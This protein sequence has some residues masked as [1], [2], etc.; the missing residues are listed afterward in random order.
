MIVEAP[1]FTTLK[2]VGG[3]GT[4][5]SRDKINEMECM[6]TR[7]ISDLVN[8]Q[9][10]Y[11]TRI[12][13]NEKLMRCLNLYCKTNYDSF[14]FGTLFYNSFI[15]LNVIQFDKNTYHCFYFKKNNYRN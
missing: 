15:Y 5:V 7:W 13:Q 14:I 8:V 10:I 4:P 12:R 9:A 2:A 6:R 11:C 3:L 1:R